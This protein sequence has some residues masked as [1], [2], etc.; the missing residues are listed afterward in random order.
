M[1]NVHNVLIGVL[2]TQTK[3]G[4]WVMFE[5]MTVEKFPHMKNSIIPKICSSSVSPTQH[6][7]VVPNLSGT[8]DWF[9]RRQFF[10]GSGPGGWGN[11]FRMIQVHNIYCALYFYYYYISF[12]SD[13]QALDPRGWGP[14]VQDNLQNIQGK[15]V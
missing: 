11:G 6:K 1:K 9:H 15:I 2:Q 14:L 8:R 3:N 7:A 13:H 4:G 10:H 12:S 5:G